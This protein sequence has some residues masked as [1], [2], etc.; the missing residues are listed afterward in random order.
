V[1]AEAL[2]ANGALI[3]V[4]SLEAAV[5]LAN[6]LAPEHL[7]LCVRAPDAFTSKAQRRARI[8]RSGPFAHR[9][10]IRTSGDVPQRQQPDRRP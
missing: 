1:A 3:L 7:E 8:G 2:A 6:R 4:E 10:R 5:D 9:L